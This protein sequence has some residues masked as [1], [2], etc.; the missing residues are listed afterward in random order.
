MQELTAATSKGVTLSLGLLNVQVNVH[1][2]VGADESRSMH[3]ACIG[4]PD[5]GPHDPTQTRQHLVCPQCGNND[6]TTL[7]KAR[8]AG[9]QLVVIPPDVL[10]EDKAAADKFKGILGLTVHP[11][12]EVSSVLMPSGKS[13]YLDLPAKNRPD[14]AIEAYNVLVALI[15]ARPNLAFMTKFALRTAIS[16]FRLEVSGEGTLILRQMADASLVRRA[17]QIPV[18]EIP[19]ASVEA[20]A[21]MLGDSRVTPFVAAEHGSGSASIISDYADAHAVPE[22]SRPSEPHT[23]G[24]VS[25]IQR[26]ADAGAVPETPASPAPVKRPPRKSAT[27]TTAATTDTTT[28]RK[29]PV[30][31]ATKRAS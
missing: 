14:G 7:V 8:D 4:T 15:K 18:L 17:P 10:V 20:A 16:I 22:G 9:G 28:T 23:L 5:S 19:D 24:V 12:A 11:A 27:K 31:R 1:G 13:Y 29:A 6:R 3:H 30:K 26:L 25:L 21:S 2:A